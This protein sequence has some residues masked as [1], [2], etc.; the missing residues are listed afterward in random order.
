VNGS[1]KLFYAAQLRYASEKL[2][3]RPDDTGF[4]VQ[5]MVRALKP[6]ELAAAQQ[7]VP[8]IG[9]SKASVNDLVMMDVLFETAEPREQVVLEDPLPA[10]LEP[11]DF[12][13]QTSSMHSQVDTPN[14]N[15][16]RG[17]GPI[18]Y[19]AFRT[20]AGLHRELHDDR[21]LTFLSHVEPGIYHFRYLARATTPGRYVVPPLRAECMY[22]PEVSGRTAA[23]TFEVVSAP[24]KQSAARI[25]VLSNAP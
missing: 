12:S 24:S 19:G 25:A 13:L 9:Q 8:S 21:V 22:S 11:I 5:R 17:L 4:S 3:T 6:S 23:T 20:V 7:T 14:V 15:Q 10:G 16:P 18:A 2:P 1:G